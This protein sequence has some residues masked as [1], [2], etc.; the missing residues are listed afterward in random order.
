MSALFATPGMTATFTVFLVLELASLVVLCIGLLTY[1]HLVLS[2]RA[3]L[4]SL[5]H[6]G[7]QIKHGYGNVLFWVYLCT[8]L[9]LVLL[10]SV[11]YIWQPR[12]F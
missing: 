11:I 10:S 6:A 12:I 9:L 1:R 8:T 3:F 4:S 5:H 2:H 7:K